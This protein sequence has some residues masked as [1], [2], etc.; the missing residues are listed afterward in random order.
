MRSYIQQLSAVVW[1][2]ALK[3]HMLSLLR[4]DSDRVKSCGVRA[5]GLSSSGGLVQACAIYCFEDTDVVLRQSN[6]VAR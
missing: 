6:A 5:V 4:I 3:V 1:R 2:P